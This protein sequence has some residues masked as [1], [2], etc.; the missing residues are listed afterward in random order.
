MQIQVEVLR[1]IQAGAETLRPGQ[2]VD[3]TSWR[4]T[5]KL[6]EQGRCRYVI[7]RPEEDPTA[8][9]RRPREVRHA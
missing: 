2:V 5:Q 9:T 4:N 1:P 7:V 3:A 6:V 8:S